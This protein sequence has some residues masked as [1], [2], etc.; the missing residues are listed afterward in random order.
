MLNDN[1]ITHVGGAMLASTSVFPQL[2]SLN[3]FRNDIGDDGALAFANSK[4]FPHLELL[5]LGDNKI[6]DQG[7]VP[8]IES[9]FF[10]QLRVL[11][12]AM[13]PLGESS[14]MAAFKVNR[15]GKLQVVYR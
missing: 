13:N 12:M 14:M 1:L 15:K 10:P 3:L 8:L 7:A 11:D 9:K 4:E 6:T 2:Q 5:Y